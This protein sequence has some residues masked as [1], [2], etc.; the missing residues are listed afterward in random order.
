MR[1]GN[2]INHS[3]VIEPSDNH[4]FFVRV[5][6]GKFVFS[7]HEDMLNALR[8]YLKA[9]DTTEQVYNNSKKNLCTDDP[10]PVSDRDCGR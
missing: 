6:C 2:S 3:I 9:P 4:G 10:A 5:G 1:F 8:A 7:N